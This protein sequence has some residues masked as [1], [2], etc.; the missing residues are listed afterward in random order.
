M[1]DT[2]WI[3]NPELDV[4]HPRK[5]ELIVRF[6]EE[7]AGKSFAQAIPIFSRLSKTMQEEGLSFTPEENT[8]IMDILTRDMSEEE[9]KRLE[10]IKQMILAQTTKLK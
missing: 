10:A 9:K 8:L 7:T 3:H 2:S 4:L 5:K 6:I 1:N